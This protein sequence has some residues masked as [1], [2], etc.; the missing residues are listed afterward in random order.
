MKKPGLII[1][2]I[3]CSLLLAASG[4]A[5]G[6]LVYDLNTNNF[7]FDRLNPFVQQNENSEEAAEEKSSGES[8]DKEQSSAASSD[9]KKESDSES[10]AENPSEVSAGSDTV[11]TLPFVKQPEKIEEQP[12]ELTAALAPYSDYTPADA[13]FGDH[14]ILVDTNSTGELNK[15]K[16]YCYQRDAGSE[17]WWNVMG[18]GKPICEEAYIGENG[19]N[20][21]PS[22]DAAVTPGGV[23][24]AGKGFYISD[25]PNTSYPLFQITEDTYWVTDPSSE[26]Y[27]QRVE[28]TD[29][30]DWTEADHMI[31]SEKS[32]QYGLVVNYNTSDTN[33]D[34]TSAIFFRCGNTP[35]KGSIAVPENVMKT[36][37]E[38]LDKDS[39]IMIFITV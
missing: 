39:N 35:T 30:K 16:I 3:L 1:T 25:K 34:R 4:T 21:D 36:I 2:E 28:G 31:T 23:F 6:F 29:K 26:F 12:A 7:H 27:N 32:Y 5:V 10:K 15:A 38:W 9:E 18:E 33:P 22:P 13:I 20:F 11:Q 19:S 17:Y 37:L 14:M 24:P 8:S